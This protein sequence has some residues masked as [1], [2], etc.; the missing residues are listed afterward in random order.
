MNAAAHHHPLR[1]SAKSLFTT[2]AI[3]LSALVTGC[4][5]GGFIADPAPP[6]GGGS[7]EAISSMPSA[8]PAEQGEAVASQIGQTD[9]TMLDFMNWTIDE[10]D[11]SWS[12]L[13]LE[14]GLEEPFVNVAFPGAGERLSSSCGG[15]TTDE[16]AFY[17]HGDDEIVVSQVFA[18]RVWEGL[19]RANSDEASAYSAGDFSVAY[20]LAHEYAHSLQ[21]ELG[22]F[23]AGLPTWMTELHADCWAGIW[24]NSAYYEGILEPGD[25]E[26]GIRTAQDLGDYD[27]ENSDHHGTPSE[28]ADAFLTGYQSG[29]PN[30]CSV[31]LG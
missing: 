23:D 17:C 19:V 15:V 7:V 11:T 13:F 22:I 21:S 10:V 25:V 9:T 18:G 28:R 24:A 27:F 12:A 6:D 20:V 1:G 26:E 5:P 4:A 30:D 31:Y 2:G 3:L 14:A 16:T 29:L 8:V